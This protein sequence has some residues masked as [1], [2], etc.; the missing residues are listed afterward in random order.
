M[1][2]AEKLLLIPEEK[3]SR[4]I[5]KMKSEV[6]NNEIESV[7]E[8]SKIDTTLT[9]DIHDQ[10]TGCNQYDDQSIKNREINDTDTGDVDS[11]SCETKMESDTNSIENK[12][13]NSDSV[14]CESDK[15]TTPF[16]DKDD[17]YFPDDLLYTKM[18]PK[19]KKKSAPKELGKAMLM[20]KWL[21]F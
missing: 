18:K 7:N 17:N 16:C 12:Q 11:N 8:E 2:Y 15:T 20:K 21:K 19:R 3:Y 9:T 1:R 10:T 6:R 13:E 14:F 5:G 4:L